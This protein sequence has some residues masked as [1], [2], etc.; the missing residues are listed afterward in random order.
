MVQTTV[1]VQYINTLKSPLV[2]LGTPCNYDCETE[3]CEIFRINQ[4][5]R[6][7]ATFI[8]T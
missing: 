2:V 1:M 3:N 6:S 4:I 7:N 8:P 5:W